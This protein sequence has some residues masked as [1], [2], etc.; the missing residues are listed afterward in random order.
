MGLFESDE[1]RITAGEVESAEGEWMSVSIHTC[2]MSGCVRKT[3][4]RRSTKEWLA[5]RGRVV[6]V[7]EDE[8]VD[9]PVERE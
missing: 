9:A 2:M 8:D 3:G 6:C 5:G 4:E 1:E 7:D